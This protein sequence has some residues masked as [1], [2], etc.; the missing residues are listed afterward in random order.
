MLYVTERCVFRL[1]REGIELIEIAPGIDLERDILARMAFRPVMKEPPTWMDE[2]IFADEPMN[3]RPELLDVPFGERLTY[4]PGGNLFFVNFEGL[5]VH[6]KADIERIRSSVEAMLSRVGHKVFAVVNY[7]R[8][9]I[10]TELIDDYIAMVKGL[11]EKYY[12]DVTRYT[13]STF[14]RLRLGEALSRRNV[15]PHLYASVA[16]AQ[17]HLGETQT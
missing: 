11:M 4:D 9:N 6:S 7:D 16:E 17:A 5:A 3:L 15:S 8:F 12:L 14:L 1:C 13:S 2:R 10:S